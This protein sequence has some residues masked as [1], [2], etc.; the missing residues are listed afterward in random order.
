MGCQCCDVQPV[1]DIRDCIVD[2]FV[3]T[4]YRFNQFRVKN[5]HTVQ[6]CL[7]ICNVIG[8]QFDTVDCRVSEVSLQSQA[9]MRTIGIQLA[10]LEENHQ[11][12]IL[13]ILRVL[14]ASGT[15]IILKVRLSR[16]R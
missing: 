3:K 7:N 12:R 8:S 15:E 2:A 1:I 10:S 4:L 6:N 14:S 16:T 11:I 13:I 5:E 9:D